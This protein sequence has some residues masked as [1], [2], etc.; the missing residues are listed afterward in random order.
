MSAEIILL[1]KLGVAIAADSAI[2]VGNRDAIFNTAQKIFPFGDKI[3]LAFLYYSTTEFMGIPIDVIFRRYMESVQT[4]KLQLNTVRE[5]LHDFVQ[6]IE[7]NGDYFTFHEFEN[8]Y[9]TLF[10]YERYKEY[11]QKREGIME[12]Q[13][14][15]ISESNLIRDTFV[16]LNNELKSKNHYQKKLQ[17]EPSKDYIKKTV[18]PLIKTFLQVEVFGRDKKDEQLFNEEEAVLFEYFSGFVSECFQWVF[19]YENIWKTSVYLVGYG[20]DSLFPSYGGINLFC[21][22][23]GKLIYNEGDF[24]EV[25]QNKPGLYIT[26]A[27]DDAIESFLNGLNFDSLFQIESDLTNYIKIEMQKQKEIHHGD[28]IFI[29]KLESLMVKGVEDIL[30]NSERQRQS[31]L[32][33]RSSLANMG[34]L[35]LA[36]Y[37][38]NLIHLQTIRRKYEL[39]SKNQATVGGPIN[40][41]MIDRYEGFRWYKVDRR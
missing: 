22:L 17:Y 41:A 4:R 11:T 39:S 12:Q 9:L 27:Q 38:E 16:A 28:T 13:T 25:S 24:G 10:F 18:V 36:D 14:T 34:L 2:T 5:Y 32:N 20:Q 37:A 33:I 3:P 35:D 40:V 30:Y 8:R 26:L 29:E 21:F 15:P 1:N 19:A 7:K 23:K 6:F 31:E